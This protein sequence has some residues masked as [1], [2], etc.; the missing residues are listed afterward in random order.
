MWVSV[1]HTLIPSRLPPLCFRFRGL[2]LNSSQEIHTHIYSLPFSQSLSLFPPTRSIYK[3]FHEK[4]GEDHPKF[5]S[6][7]LLM[8]WS[9]GLLHWGRVFLGASCLLPMQLCPFQLSSHP[10]LYYSHLWT[11]SPFSPLPSPPP[12][13]PFLSS[14]YQWRG[15]LG[16][17][18]LL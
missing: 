4:A 14:D 8:A 13:P 17:S 18:L 5:R 15:Q 12:P 11:A 10:C 6:I 7:F 2:N 3:L 1:S 16:S 9:Q